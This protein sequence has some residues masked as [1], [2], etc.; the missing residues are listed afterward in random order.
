MTTIGLEELGV[1]LEILCVSSE[2]W[3]GAIKA[4]A[5][6]STEQVGASGAE[7][8][9]DY[10]I[11]YYL[12]D[13]FDLLL[14]YYY[15]GHIIPIELNA[16]STKQFAVGHGRGERLMDIPAAH[17][18]LL[19]VPY[20]IYENIPSN[21]I[22][23][24][25]SSHKYQGASPRELLLEASR[26]NNTSLL[27]EVLHSQSSTQ[28][29]KLLNESTDGVGNYCLHIAASYGSCTSQPP[30]QAHRPSPT[31]KVLRC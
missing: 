12:F 16:P 17:L 15:Y 8:R 19:A 4:T 21:P 5:R 29:S 28:I 24:D 31:K 20:L 30:S 9:L 2:A 25:P 14:I 26:R 6:V 1:K 11:I 22:S 10:F 23:P 7:P 18:H 13:L 3:I 27:S